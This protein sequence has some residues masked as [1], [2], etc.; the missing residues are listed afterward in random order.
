M[1][2]PD[3]IITTRD[4]Y[5]HSAEHYVDAVGTR[6]S[7]EFE[8]PLDQ[9]VLRVFAETAASIEPSNVIDVGCGTGRVAGFLAARGLDVAGID[10]SEQMI[11]AARSAHPDVRFETGALTALP[12]PDSSI[13]AAAYWYSIIATPP[14]ELAQVWRELDRVLTDRATGLIAFQAGDGEAIVRADA[15]GS[16]STLTL[17]H[18]SV[19]RVAESLA[20]EGFEVTAQL[21][22]QPALRHETTPQ[23]FL[24][25]ETTGAT[26]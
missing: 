3:H 25:V 1:G 7:A 22:R 2:E 20:E 6:I 5:D 15:Y 24:F 18:H 16:S 13:T 14:Q 17:Y 21:I 4:V 23:A 11:R 9:A 12:I 8:A 10:I 26:P 19:R